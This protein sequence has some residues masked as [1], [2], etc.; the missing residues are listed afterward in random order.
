MTFELFL[1]F[2]AL[3]NVVAPS[4]ISRFFNVIIFILAVGVNFSHLLIVARSEGLFW[5][6]MQ[7]DVVMQHCFLFT[8]PSHYHT[9]Y[10]AGFLM[11]IHIAIAL[12]SVATTIFYDGSLDWHIDETPGAPQWITSEPL[13]RHQRFDEARALKK[14]QNLIKKLSQSKLKMSDLP[15]GTTITREQSEQSVK[16]TTYDRLGRANVG[17]EHV[18][19]SRSY[20]LKAPGSK[21]VTSKRKW[22][23]RRPPTGSS[24]VPAKDVKTTPVPDKMLPFLDSGAIPGQL[25]PI[26]KP[27]EIP[28]DMKPIEKRDTAGREEVHDDSPLRITRM[29]A[30]ISPLAYLANKNKDNMEKQSDYMY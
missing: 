30:L 12:L 22:V 17:P 14:K 7:G 16:T 20:T 11:F 15:P 2:V 27:V 13:H 21:P 4:H 8:I 10:T 23:V 3:C 28:S 1:L 6:C 5:K 9:L 19:M 18:T 29:P 25:K 24:F 26:G